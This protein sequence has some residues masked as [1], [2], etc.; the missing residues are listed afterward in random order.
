MIVDVWAQP[1]FVAAPDRRAGRP[2]P[3]AALWLALLD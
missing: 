3:R 2:R 1:N